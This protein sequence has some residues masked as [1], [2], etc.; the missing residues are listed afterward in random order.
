MDVLLLSSVSRKS[1]IEINTYAIIF[2]DYLAT[3]FRL[4]ILRWQL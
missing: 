1:F 3:Y 4:H 2:I